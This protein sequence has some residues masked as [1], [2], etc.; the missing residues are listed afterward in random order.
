MVIE[1]KKELNNRMLDF[2][3]GRITVYKFWE[4]YIENKNYRLLIYKKRKHMNF[5]NLEKFIEDFQNVSLTTL[6][7]R[8][9]IFWLIRR[10][11]EICKIKFNPYN[12]DEERLNFLTNLCPY[13]IDIFDC[14]WFE[15][16]L[17]IENMSIKDIDNVDILKQK[18]K[19]LFQYEKYPPKWLQGADWPIVNDV[20]AFFVKQSSNPDHPFWEEQ[21]IDYFF[22]D[23]EGNEIIV[24]QLP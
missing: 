18:I 3:E 4:E 20:P 21:P 12:S 22:K 17:G 23:S 16:V 6:Y 10:Y 19:N 7:G 8:V 1:A 24:N 11:L 9:R 2:V 15:R 14:E 13:W 5:W